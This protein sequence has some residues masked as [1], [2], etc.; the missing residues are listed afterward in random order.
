M[1]YVAASPLAVGERLSRL[2]LWA[3]WRRRSALRWFLVVEHRPGPRAALG[4]SA[5]HDGS[6]L[7]AAF[8][9]DGIDRLRPGAGCDGGSGAR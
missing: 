9:Y 2:V 7:S 1:L 5:R 3:P 8:A 6:A 4:L